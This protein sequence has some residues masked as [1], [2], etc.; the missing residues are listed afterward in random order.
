MGDIVKTLTSF[1]YVIIVIVMV[2]YVLIAIPYFIRKSKKDK[3]H[4]ADFES[5][6]PNISKVYTQ[7]SAVSDGSMYVFNVDGEAAHN[8]F[9]GSKNGFYV[10]K[11]THTVN[12]QFSWSRPGVL[13][14]TVTTTVG[15]VDIEIEVAEATKYA[16]RYNKKAKEFVLEEYTPK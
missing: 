1:P 6:N 10:E 11:G 4:Q 2:A 3:A 13:H 7:T 8:F 16:I 14:K 5:T 9:E 12:V 15:P